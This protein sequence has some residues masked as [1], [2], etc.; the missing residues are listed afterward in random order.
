MVPYFRLRFGNYS[1]ILDGNDK[2]EFLLK[3]RGANFGNLA[4]R[5][6]L[7]RAEMRYADLRRREC[8]D[9]PQFAF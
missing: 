7:C 4:P 9:R 1:D 6:S 8:R 5:P 2:K 3:R